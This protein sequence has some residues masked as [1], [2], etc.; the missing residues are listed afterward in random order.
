MQQQEGGDRRIASLLLEMM[1]LC[2]LYDSVTIS[3]H[4]DSLQHRVEQLDGASFKSKAIAL[5][6]K[7]ADCSIWIESELLLQV[8]AS[9]QIRVKWNVRWTGRLI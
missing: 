7:T 2:G 1:W 5:Y 4:W 8:K 9:S 6:W 3:M